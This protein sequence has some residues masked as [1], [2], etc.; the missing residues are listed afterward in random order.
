MSGAASP[1]VGSP[2]GQQIDGAQL[3]M[4]MVQATEQMVQ[5][6]EQAAAAAQAAAQAASTTS[7]AATAS[8]Q[9]AK[10]TEWY[11]MLPKPPSFSPQTREEE[12]S[13]FREWAWQLEQYLLAVDAKY[14]PDIEAIRNNLN[15][16]CDL[17]LEMSDAKA[18]RATFL[19]GLLASLL[20]GRPLLVLKSVEQGNGFEGLRLLIKNGQP[21]NRN[22][23]LG[24]LQLLMAWPNFDQKAAMLPQILKLE[25]S[26]REYERIS[27]GELQKELKFSILMKVVTGHLKTHLQVSLRE[28]TTYEQLREAIINYD[29]ATIRWTNTMALGNAMPGQEDGPTPMD[30]DR[31]T[32][33][34]KGKHKGKQKGKFDGQKG[35]GDGKGKGKSSW[36]S[37]KGKSQDGKGKAPAWNGQSNSWHKGWKGKQPSKGDGKNGKSSSKGKGNGACHKCGNYGHFARECTVRV[38]NESQQDD[39]SRS[40]TSA[41][42]YTT[43]AATQSTNQ[44]GS[45]VNRIAFDMSTPHET[46]LV[47]DVSCLDDFSNL[48]VAMISEDVD[49]TLQGDSQ[50]ISCAL[51]CCDASV[52]DSWVLSDSQDPLREFAQDSCVGS[53]CSVRA[54]YTLFDLVQLDDFEHFI[55]T[56]KREHRL[57][58]YEMSCET[59]NMSALR[60]FDDSSDFQPLVAKLLNKQVKTDNPFGGISNAFASE[61]QRDIHCN[62]FA[63]TEGCEIVLDSGSDAT[64]IPVSMADAGVESSTQESYLRD[65]QGSQI[66]TSGVRDISIVAH[67]LDGRAITFK[68]RG[69]VS[70]KV[71]QPLISYGKLL[72]R[73]W[74]VDAEGDN[75]GPVLKHKCGAQIPVNF[76]HHS[77]TIHGEVRMVSDLNVRAITVDVPRSWQKLKNGWYD[78]DDADRFILNVSSASNFVDTSQSL[79]LHEFPFRTTIGYNDSRG[80]EVIELCERVFPL[81]DKAAKITGRYQ[82]LF[83]LASRAVLVP[84][85]FGLVVLDSEPSRTSSSRTEAPPEQSVSSSSTAIGTQPQSTELSARSPVLSGT[86]RPQPALPESIAVQQSRD[87]VTVAG[88]QVRKDSAIAVLRA[89]CSFLEVSQ[90]GSKSKLWSRVLATLDKQAM[91]AEKQLS[92]AVLQES[93]EPARPVTS[94]APPGEDEVKRHELTHIPFQSWCTACNM[95]KGRADSH[96]A[97]PT[98]LQHREFPVISFDYCFTGKSGEALDG[99]SDGQ[100]LTAVVV[101]DSHSNAVHCIPVHGKHQGRYVA[102]QIINFISF[103]G[104]GTVCLRTDNEP[105]TLEIQRMVQRARQSQDLKTIVEN[106]RILDKG[107]NPHAEK[108]VD[109]VRCQAMVF[110]HALEQNLKYDI[111]PGHPLFSWAFVHAGWTLTRFSLQ[112]KVSAYQLISGHPYHGKLVSYGSPIM[113]YVGDSNKHKGDPKWRHG[114]FLGKSLSN[115][116]Y[117]ASVSGNL[118]LTRSIKDIFPN[119]KDHMEEY[120]QVVAFP[121]QAEASFGNVIEPDGARARARARARGGSLMMILWQLCRVWM[122]KRRPILRMIL[123]QMLQ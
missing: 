48:R 100:K 74:S 37:G 29:Q 65:A 35:K 102:K 107:S 77:L 97:D 68:D 115:D 45:R 9:T 64:V 121:W 54:S 117:I 93:V 112:C 39:S 87:V 47:F 78:V 119:W 32:E 27:G 82:N 105:A 46:D 52:S 116:M 15:T 108:A 66:A 49:L 55:E 31:V 11:K 67:S 34:G 22:R 110:V 75:G 24:L 92:D 70:S 72:R 86:P 41:T 33:K 83:T 84:S 21:T 56:A 98:T 101:H 99:A 109:R 94:A 111:P 57:D 50:Q 96:R 113:V 59:P 62:V 114:I 8:S 18:Q 30:V 43:A 17:V 90:S 14:G 1:A 36:Q 58:L 88:V 104:Y 2:V 5:V 19:Y 123:D 28:D 23:S 81:Q 20:K 106:G 60:R 40:A 61:D 7:A 6:T 26:I 85:D 4:R 3:A 38:V 80:W 69:H 120:R 71:E 12:L 89:A 63:V 91:L 73:G 53:D 44:Q 118:R 95:A 103:L 16:K 42:T 13:M 10:P 25:D 76:R 79:L 122:M 51:H